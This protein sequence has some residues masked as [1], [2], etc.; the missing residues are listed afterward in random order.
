MV[1]FL[2]LRAL[3]HLR[4]LLSRQG[5]MPAFNPGNLSILKFIDLLSHYD[6]AFP[7]ILAGLLGTRMCLNLPSSSSGTG[8]PMLQQVI[9]TCKKLTNDRLAVVYG[10]EAT[11]Q[12]ASDSRRG[13][14]LGIASRAAWYWTCRCTGDSFSAR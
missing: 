7:I 4:F 6:P 2:L 8:K 9:D 5:K 13:Y 3:I 1:K 12:K 10:H 14:C 11:G